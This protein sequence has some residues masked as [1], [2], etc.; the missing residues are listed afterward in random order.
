MISPL[1]SLLSFQIKNDVTLIS[2]VT[3]IVTLQVFEKE[4][5]NII[6]RYVKFSNINAEDEEAIRRLYDEYTYLY[7]KMI[8][9][10][11]ID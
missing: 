8:T 3:S 4:E 2:S 6:D 7:E 11:Q 10:L 9:K 1:P 5:K